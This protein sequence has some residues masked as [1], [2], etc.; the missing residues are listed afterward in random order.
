MKFTIQVLIES[1]DALPL[2][3]PV[4]T[5]E[6]SCDRIEDVGLRLEEAKEILRGLQEQL[7][8]HQLADHLERHRP[9]PCCHRR[10]PIKGYHPLRF[11]SA[12]GDL[13]LRSP[14][15]YEC[16]CEGRPAQATFSPLNK[17]LTTHLA[18]ELEFLQA[19]WAAHV[20][21]GAVADLLQD[22]LPIDARLNDE[23]IRM[24]VFKTAERLEAELGSEQFAFDAGCQLE[25]EDS[26]EPGPPITVGLDGGY[27]RGRERRPGGTGCFEVIAGKSIPEEG[28]S[29][30]FAG[31]GQIDT[32]PKRRDTKFSGRRGCCR[33]NMLR[34]SPTAVIPCEHYRHTYIPIQSISWTGFISACG[35]NSSHR[36]RGDFAVP[37]IA[38]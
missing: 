31:V 13:E 33:G 16:A 5:I 35:W 38:Q 26:P 3:V 30:V 18:P 28:Q 22:V 12:F 6:R 2:S 1:P 10:R 32:K 25:I 23:T 27:I 36:R 21:F 8:R 9:C 14:R 19:K 29:K 17:L 11:R 20:S 4:Q 7:V 37:M 24:Q 15:W 34:F